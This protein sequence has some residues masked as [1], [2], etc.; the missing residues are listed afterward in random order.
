MDLTWSL[1]AD[2]KGVGGE[3]DQTNLCMICIRINDDGAGDHDDQNHLELLLK[4]RHL[5]NKSLHGAPA[6]DRR[7]GDRAH[8]VPWIIVRGGYRFTEM[9]FFHV[10]LQIP[11]LWSIIRHFTY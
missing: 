2:W 11:L 3:G 1:L 10:L 8:A 4:W 7:S 9:T 6:R 5:Q